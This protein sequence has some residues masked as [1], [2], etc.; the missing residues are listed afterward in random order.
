MLNLTFEI[1]GRPVTPDNLRNALERAILQQFENQLRSKL[2]GIRDPETGEFPV[3]VVRGHDLESLSISMNGSPKLIALVKERL[4]MLSDES[5][6]KEDSVAEKPQGPPVSFVCHASENKTLARQIA[7]DF[8][9]R[10]I[11]TFFDEWEIRPGDSIRQ[12]ID[13]GLGEC[14]HFIV[15]L[16]PESIRK[17]WVNAEIDAAFMAKVEGKCKFIPLRS[18]LEVEELPPLLRAL[19]SP[20]L[21]NYEIDIAVV[22]NF[23]HG[24]TLKPPLGPPPR[25][26][27][28]SSAGKLGI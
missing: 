12:K 21:S 13:L 25:V 17:P 16:T 26:I 28:E 2:A 20:A 15:L 9:S 8:Q 1:D 18:N 4:G 6:G 23:I 19:H 3:V 10:G 5:S 11:K 7:T 14:T 24:A 22:I 27:T